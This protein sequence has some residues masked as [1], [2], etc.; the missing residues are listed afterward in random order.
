[1]NTQTRT[2][3]S[4]GGF[5]EDTK[6]ARTTRTRNDEKYRFNKIQVLKQNIET[7]FGKIEDFAGQEDDIDLEKIKKLF[8]N[9]IN[10]NNFLR[11]YE[12]IKASSS[13]Q[14]DR[15]I[16]ATQQERLMMEKRL[17]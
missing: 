4:G 11:N 10:E 6:S 5:D 16:K 12:R 17:G 15:Q 1:M 2:V 8:K 13:Q 7:N 14:Q 3:R 9:E